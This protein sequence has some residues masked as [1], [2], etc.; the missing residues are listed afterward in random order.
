MFRLTLEYFA[1]AGL[2]EYLRDTGSIF[3]PVAVLPS[4][5]FEAQEV[6]HHKGRRV[7]ET[8]QYCHL[9]GGGRQM[10]S[11]WPCPLAIFEATRRR[12]GV[13]IGLVVAITSSKG[14]SEATRAVSTALISAMNACAAGERD[15]LSSQT[16]P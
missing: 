16:N 3:P 4:L 5:P 15:R 8:R 7:R 1:S 2:A 9:R 14:F 11:H 13:P 12:I 10:R 6:D